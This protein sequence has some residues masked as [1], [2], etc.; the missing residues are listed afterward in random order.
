MLAERQTS[1]QQALPKPI[2]VMIVDDAVVV[3][4]L[5]S[6]WLQEDSDSEI[7]ATYRNGAEAV[8][9]TR[10]PDVIILDIDMPEMDGMTAL[11]LLIKK[12]P[13]A[14]IVMASTLTVRN[15]DYTLRSLSMGAHDY[16]AKPAT[17]RDVTFA[18]D[19]RREIVAKVIA[20]GRRA[21]RMSRETQFKTELFRPRTTE[22]GKP[23]VISAP[24]SLAHAVSPRTIAQEMRQKPAAPFASEITL[25]PLQTAT[26]KLLLI[27]ASTG[28]PKAIIDLLQACRGV[29]Q[30]M[31]VV[32]VQ[33]MPPIFTQSFAENISKHL[34]VDA[35]EAQNGEYLEA[36]RIYVAP[37]GRHLKL[38]RQQSGHRVLLDD[39]PPVNYF[40]PS[41]DVA[42]HSAGLA[43]GPGVLGVMLTGMGSDGMQGS[44]AMIERGGTLL[45]QD[46]AT[47]IV[48]GMPGSVARKGLCSA[49][50]PVS[51]LAAIISRLVMRCGK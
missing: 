38:E 26:P 31:P 19:F 49:V 7:V 16:V 25:R 14:A 20:L 36:G 21:K 48:W 10:Q 13:E 24:T 44:T 37:G 17:N 6:R 41:V 23:N 15:A 43:Y 45:A 8:A 50:A 40:R 9:G 34:S 30:S 4:G 33:H 47:S 46:E 27:G 3:R 18:T 32:I 42:F 1:V 5:L 12:W 51:E 2:R 39:S 35:S 29:V 22:T 11:P 28:G